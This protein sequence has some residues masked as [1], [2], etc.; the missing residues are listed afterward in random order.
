MKHRVL[1]CD[2]LD[3]ATLG[4]TDSFEVDYQPK[5]TRDELL[6]KVGDYEVLVI[7]SRTK[8]D[9]QVI[10]NAKRLKVIARPGSGIDN[11]DARAAN[12]KGIEIVSSPE[13]LVESV[14]EHV[15]GLMLALARNTTGADATMKSGRWEKDRFVGIELKGKT[16]G[17]AGLGRI[18]RRVAE[19]AGVLGMSVIGYDVVE[20]PQDTLSA[21]KIRMVDLD[22]LFASSDF[23]TLHVPLT[24]E[25]RRMVDQR[26]LSLMK[27]SAFIINTSRGEVIDEAALYNVLKAGEIGGAA[28]DV[29]EKEPPSPDAPIVTAPRTITTQHIGGQTEDAQRSAVTIAGAKINQ[30][31]SPRK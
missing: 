31:F 11:I 4:L 17:I 2:S 28:L 19:I 27:K 15:V 16:M 5:I 29:F 21:L 9:A 22:T 10:E 8:V 3:V 18:G 14:A 13:S 6:A 24:T 1:V 7:R 25:T 30:F 12:A 23:I 26:R 20:V